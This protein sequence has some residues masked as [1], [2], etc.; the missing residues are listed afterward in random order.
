MSLAALR[1]PCFLGS[2]YSGC[3]I[4]Q[5]WTGCA[6]GTRRALRACWSTPVPADLPGWVIEFAGSFGMC[7]PSCSDNMLHVVALCEPRTKEDT[8]HVHI[9]GDITT[10]QAMQRHM[11]LSIEQFDSHCRFLLA[12]SF[13]AFQALSKLLRGRL[14]PPN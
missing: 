11:H 2:S 1:R 7:G 4:D 10:L 8:S 3:A 14:V 5:L 9:N 6:N 12:D 13:E